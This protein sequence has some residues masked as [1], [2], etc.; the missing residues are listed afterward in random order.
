[1]KCLV[2]GGAG[3]IGS[4][5]CEKLLSFDH[6]VLCIDNLITGNQENIANL[7]SNSKF[8]FIK[9]DITKPL[10][11]K[12]TA[13]LI[14]HLASPASP[15]KD[16]PLSYINFPIETLSVN[17]YGTFLLM[18]KAQQWKAKLLFTS[19]SEVYGDPQVHPQ[20]EDYWGNVNPV[21]VRSCYDE[22][23][24]FGE[25]MIVAFGRKFKT[26]S[27]IARVFNTYGPKMP[28]DGRVIITLIKQA[29]GD[30]PLTVFGDGTQTRSFCYIDD[31][32]DGL[33]K[34]M[35]SENS[36]GEVFN[37]GGKDEWTV[38]DL[39]KKIKQLTSSGS[40]IIFTDLPADDPAKRKP[41]IEKI[42]QI[43]NWEPRVTLEEGVLQ[44]VKFLKSKQN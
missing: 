34:M 32:V 38:L 27:C 11:A 33:I 44:T 10:P 35:F 18:E 9:H 8:Q 37:I 21:G 42:Q 1:M 19:S 13:E 5:L 24:R 2:A 39:A 41:N 20:K 17:S 22:G 43:L 12:I 14:F 40:E 25:A 28:D 23:K 31:L 7:L 30:K 16:N 26:S 29:L 4:H 6:E 3:F 36:N 15:N